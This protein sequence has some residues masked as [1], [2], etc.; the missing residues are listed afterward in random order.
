MRRLIDPVAG[1]LECNHVTAFS[2]EKVQR[3]Y[4]CEREREVRNRKEACK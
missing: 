2:Q 4:V 1:L 3:C